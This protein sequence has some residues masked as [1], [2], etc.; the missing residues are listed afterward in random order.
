MQLR[1]ETKE[2]MKIYQRGNKQLHFQ[3]ET[4]GSQNLPFIKIKLKINL[5]L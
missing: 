5:H 2:K 4:F 1:S 3:W